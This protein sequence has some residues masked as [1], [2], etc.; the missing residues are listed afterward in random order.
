MATL[1]T[2]GKWRPKRRTWI[3]AG[4][5]LGA[6]ASEPTATADFIDPAALGVTIR[7]QIDAT[8]LD[9]THLRV[10]EADTAL[11]V[12]PPLDGSPLSRAAYLSGIAI[13]QVDLP[14]GVQAKDVSLEVGFAVAYPWELTSATVTVNTPSLSIVPSIGV[15]L[16]AGGP[17]LN[18]SIGMAVDVIPSHS[19]A[20]AIEPGT[21]TETS[22]AKFPMTTPVSSIDLENTRVSVSG[23]IG[24]V[25]LQ[26]FV[27]LTVITE[28]SQITRV[29]YSDPMSM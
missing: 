16:G 7:H 6:F 1:V 26:V 23:A 17:S 2:A 4:L 9:S 3:V 14:A 28:S 22:L 25:N 19:L 13:G 24:Q 11:K 20:L 21:V 29:I 5:V 8:A 12:V 18:P 27:R 10:T 15:G